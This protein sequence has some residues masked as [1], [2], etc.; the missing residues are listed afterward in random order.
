[1]EKTGQGV[2]LKV[3][4]I[5]QDLLLPSIDL[6]TQSPLSVIQEI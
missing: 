5:G 6:L 4:I 2:L 1:M 3:I